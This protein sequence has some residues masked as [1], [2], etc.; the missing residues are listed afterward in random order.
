MSL[1]IERLIAA[2]ADRYRIER[3]LGQGGMATVYLAQDLKHDRKVAIKVLRAELAAV[4]GAER[5][6]SEIKTTA[7]LQHPHI[8][9]LHDSGEAD[10]F[11][12]YVMP[13]I[14]GESLRDRLSREKQLP[15][16]DAIRIATEVAGA[17]DYA[18]RHGV[19]HRDIKPENILLHDGRALVADFGIALAASKAGGTRMTET[20]MS[21]GTP[22]YMSPEQAMGEREITARSDVYA[23][24]C[25]TYEM[26]LGEPPFTGPTAQAIVAKVMTADPVTITGQRRTVPPHVEAAVFTALEKLPA[27]RYSTAAEFAQALGGASVTV[28]PGS[29]ISQPSK[30]SAGP[31]RAISAVL[32]LIVLALLGLAAWSF[33]HRASASGPAVYDAA[34]P[35]DAPMTFAYTAAANA[36]GTPLRNLSVATN[37]EFAVYVAPRGDST[38]LWYRS[39]RDATVRP[40]ASTVGATAPRLSPEGSLVAYFVGGT[41]MVAPVAGG[42]ARRLFSGQAGSSINWLSRDTL[43]ALHQDGTRMALLDAEAGLIEER[44]LPARCS[45]GSMVLTRKALLC[46]WNSISFFLDPVTGVQSGEFRFRG[47][48]GRPGPLVRGSGL[49]VVEDRYLIYLSTDGD[50]RAAPFDPVTV[51]LGRPVSLV[52]GIRREGVGEAHYEITTAG[53]LVYAPGQDAT[54][55][56][57]VRLRQSGTPEPLPMPEGTFHRFDLS[58]DGRWL[59]AAVSVTTGQELRVYD[60]RDG[61]VQTWLRADYVR[62]PLWSPTGEDLVVTVRDSTRW[63]VLLGSQR[64]SSLPDTLFRTD[65]TNASLDAVDFHSPGDLILQ[66]WDNSAVYRMD[67]RVPSAGPREVVRGDARFGSVS[68]DGKHLAYQTVDGN[69]IMVT[70]YPGLGRRWQVAADG[71]EPFW[72]AS[73]T[74]LYRS[75]ISWYQVRIDPDTGEPVGQA[76]LWGRDPR[77]SDTSGWSNR[78]SHDGGIIYVQGPAQVSASYLRVVPNFVA[79]MKSAVEAAN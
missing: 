77:F 44:P 56:R 70:A 58:P 39:L 47:P 55:G 68:P 67:P 19:I 35:D 7:N 50:L 48:D 42:D 6:L 43:L 28:R 71:A 45:F 38:M 13:F 72:L 20:G 25:I 26:L 57:I 76:T 36:Y 49:T 5:F 10:S 64:T 61:Q 12:Y 27:D 32:G 40:L 14:E 53:A 23:L 52:R 73:N 22:T 21:L 11:L 75:G 16:N 51:L 37:G 33:S 66:Q 4:I 31:W 63:S 3:E 69:R 29:R 62:H 79:Q 24:G 9:A 41:V 34:L 18:H 54:V 74:L 2:L 65:S 46:N 30:T 59:A 17:L 8:L 60:L 78:P 1:G 15:I